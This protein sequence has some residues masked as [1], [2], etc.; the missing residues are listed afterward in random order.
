MAA[1]KFG[2]PRNAPDVCQIRWWFL[3]FRSVHLH[4]LSS[5]PILRQDTDP[6]LGQCEAADAS[7]HGMD[8]PFGFETANS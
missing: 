1:G 7:W 3:T 4:S 8:L 6:M 5:S 2:L